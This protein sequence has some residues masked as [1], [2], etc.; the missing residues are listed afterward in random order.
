MPDSVI[1]TIGGK[2]YLRDEI[3][4]YIP[5]HDCYIE[6]FG[7]AAWVLLAKEPVRLEVYNDLD[8]ELFNFFKVLKERT[9][10]FV[11][12]V[13]LLPYSREFFEYMRD[14][15]PEDEFDRAIRF[16]YL[17]RTCFGGKRSSQSFGV[18]GADR[19]PAFH[20]YEKIMPMVR[21]LR[22]V[23]IENLDFRE[24]FEKYSKNENTFIYVDAPY[25][26]SESAYGVS[27]TEQ[28]HIDLFKVLKDYSGKWLA[29]YNDCEFIRE[30][31][32]DFCIINT[33][34]VQYECVKKTVDNNRKE[35]KEVLIANYDLYEMRTPLFEWI[36][37]RRNGG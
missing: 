7:G 8:S 9:D 27:F 31:Y 24:C 4:Q 25:Y 16:Y 30:L 6:L 29:S 12:M 22:D 36:N 1:T 10:E 3:L 17:N 18:M 11:M 28:D 2:R 13:E 35:R 21:R 37:K 15:E 20:R 19:P 23:I 14:S 34:T 5:Q 33:E 26:G 32:K